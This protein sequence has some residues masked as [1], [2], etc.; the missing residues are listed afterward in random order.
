MSRHQR[1]HTQGARIVRDDAR[2]LLNGAVQASPTLGDLPIATL[3][4]TGSITREVACDGKVAFKT[5]ERA[6]RVAK[7]KGEEY[8]VEQRAYPCPFCHSFHIA[9]EKQ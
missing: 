4:A 7:E 5:Y 2:S 3:I 8:S 9:T 6:A 1:H